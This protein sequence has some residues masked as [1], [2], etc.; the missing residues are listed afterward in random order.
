MLP[1]RVIFAPCSSEQKGQTSAKVVTFSILLIATQS[2]SGLSS[3]RCTSPIVRSKLWRCPRYAP[4][5]AQHLVGGSSLSWPAILSS[6][7][8]TRFSSVS[9]HPSAPHHWLV[10]YSGLRLAS[11]AHARHVMPC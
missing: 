6:P 8:K 3:E 9:K 1:P 11:V 4:Y 7:R 2:P 5:A 10:R